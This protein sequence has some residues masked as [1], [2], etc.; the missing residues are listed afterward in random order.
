MIYNGIDAKNINNHKTFTKTKKDP[1]ILLQSGM[2]HPAKG[3][4]LTIKAVEELHKA[5][6]KNIELWLAGSG[7]IEDLGIG[8]KNKKWLKVL[9]QVSNLPEIRKKVN[10]EIVS[11][12]KE[13][14]GRV[15]IE[16]MMG[17][18]PVIGSASGGTK[19]LIQ[20]NQNGLLFE[21]N[22]VEDLKEKI[23]YLA[24]NRKEIKRLG[25]NAYRKT[26]QYFLIERTAKEVYALYQELIKK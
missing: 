16:A 1:L 20:D 12:K 24:D 25:E 10:V 17:Q 23:K 3:Q 13:A 22:N 19:E 11:S 21:P 5:G 8:R 6:Y 18:I 14:S 4:D 7:K 15:T 26:K 2:I 9:G